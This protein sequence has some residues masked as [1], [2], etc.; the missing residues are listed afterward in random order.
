MTANIFFFYLSLSFFIFLFQCAMED[1]NRAIPLTYE[2]AILYMVG[3][4]IFV[5]CA[6]IFWCIVHLVLRFLWAG[7]NKREDIAHPKNERILKKK[8]SWMKRR[9]QKMEE[10]KEEHRPEIF[11]TDIHSK[12]L[13]S[14][15][16][17]PSPHKIE[18]K[19]FN[20]H[21]LSSISK[22]TIGNVSS[23][24]KKT[25]GNLN[26]SV[27]GVIDSYKGAE[28]TWIDTKR[29][30]VVSSLICMVILHPT[31]TRQSLFLFMCVPINDRIVIPGNT[32]SPPIEIS[33][34]LRKDVQLECYTPQHWAFSLLVGLPGV[35]LYVVGT[36]VITF[37]VLYQRRHKLTIVGPAGDETRK[38]Y[39]F[40]Y[41]GYSIYYWEVVIMTRKVSMVIVAV[42]GLRATVQTQALMAL[43]VVLL[44]GAAHIY[45]K[46]FDVPVLDRLELYG[47]LTAFITL[48][49]GMFFFTQDVENSPFFL[50]VITIIIMGSNFAFITYWSVSLYQALCEEI[51]LMTRFH[52]VASIFCHGC[53]EKYC[54]NCHCTQK[55]KRCKKKW[56]AH[57]N[58]DYIDSDNEDSD[59]EDALNAVQLRRRAPRDHTVWG[60]MAVE[61]VEKES[62]TN[63]H[64]RRQHYKKSNSKKRALTMEPVR[65]RESYNQAQLKLDNAIRSSAISQQIRAN[66]SATIFNDLGIFVE[67]KMNIE[68]LSAPPLELLPKI[69]P[70]SLP[71]PP[72]LPGPPSLPPPPG[73]VPKAKVNPLARSRWKKAL[74][75]IVSE[76]KIS[77]LDKGLS[78]RQHK[79]RNKQ[80]SESIKSTPPGNLPPG[81][82]KSAHMIKLEP[83]QQQQL[84]LSKSPK[85]RWKS[86]KAK[87]SASRLLAS[88]TKRSKPAA[89]D[90]EMTKKVKRKGSRKERL[91]MIRRHTIEEDQAPEIHTNPLILQQK[92]TSREERLIM[93]R[94]RNSIDEVFG[95]EQDQK[96]QGY[97]NPLIQ[98]QQ[99]QRQI[100]TDKLSQP[101]YDPTTGKYYVVDKNTGVSE[102]TKDKFSM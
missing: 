13:P 77:S 68:M 37:F 39:G 20:S 26:H 21:R 81:N 24:S 34:Y 40:I 93:M 53:T 57:H 10:V 14:P 92:R 52:I 102:W 46:P 8:H 82:F 66:K 36:P 12:P 5:A 100:D 90:V 15:L 65:H 7:R 84:Q 3:P 48:Y 54:K 97:I 18:R 59:D 99:R 79:K 73:R 29:Y 50:A 71:G 16:P 70:P 74:S 56:Q 43:L 27:H 49:F 86:A 55:L 88:K 87:L 45:A 25:L 2:K 67:S 41:R 38:T 51:L 62:L 23:L 94:Q 96:P 101:I 91:A 33:V 89:V 31:L 64:K 22:K 60:S 47:L 61:G 11:S 9:L 1:E 72:L 35:L 4:L 95:S 6:T 98:H 85:S 76:H 75:G 32:T 58:P 83:K 63:I 42:F 28:W 80:N 17:S 69:A 44:A 19:I 78:G 30:L